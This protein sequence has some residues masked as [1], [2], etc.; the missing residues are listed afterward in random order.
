MFFVILLT[1]CL[2]ISTIACFSIRNTKKKTKTAAESRRLDFKIQKKE[3]PNSFQEICIYDPENSKTI[4]KA[5]ITTTLH[6]S[7]NPYSALFVDSDSYL[8][9]NLVLAFRTPCFYLKNRKS[10]FEHAG[11]IYSK[12]YLLNK[13]KYAVLGHVSD[14]LHDFI[15]KHDVEYIYSSYLPSNYSQNVLESNHVELKAPLKSVDKEFLKEFVEIFS[16]LEHE[17]ESKCQRICKE[18]ALARSRDDIAQKSGFFE[19]L[20]ADAAKKRNGS[21]KKIKASWC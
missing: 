18:F 17:N 3:M 8:H 13:T 9:L 20:K 11:R 14:K 15:C 10:D 5:F 6:S 19:K 7:T 2:V 21:S 12:P 1:S 16:S 4:R